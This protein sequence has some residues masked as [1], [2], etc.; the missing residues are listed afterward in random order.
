MTEREAEEIA[1][2]C[3][4]AKRMQLVEG[5]KQLLDEAEA[6]IRWLLADLEDAETGFGCGC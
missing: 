3:R 2:R 5:T 4:Q 6:A 1:D